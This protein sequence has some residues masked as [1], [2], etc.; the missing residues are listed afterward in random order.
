[1]DPVELRSEV[2]KLLLENDEGDI[3]R[4]IFPVQDQPDS[5]EESGQG[6]DPVPGQKDCDEGIKVRKIK[7]YKSFLSKVSPVFKTMFN[8]QWNKSEYEM[9]DLV[10]FDQFEAFKLFMK[11]VYGLATID[12]LTVDEAIRVHFY[13]H[14]YQMDPL[15]E[16][17]RQVL[18]KQMNQGIKDKPYSVMELIDCIKMAELYSLKEFKEQLNRVKLDIR[19]GSDALLFYNTCVN[20]PTTF[21]G[22]IHQVIS[23]LE[24]KPVNDDWPNDLIIRVLELNRRKLKEFRGQTLYCQHYGDFYDF[25]SCTDCK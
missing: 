16:Q 14:K 13:S 10:D 1:M 20:Q 7:G 11:V 15:T 9:N 23:F 24:S 8:D 19:N 12:T 21:N 6:S 4:F 3:V 17:V 18:T 5:S 2:C 25:E 22:L